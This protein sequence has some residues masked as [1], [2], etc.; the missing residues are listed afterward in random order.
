M[1]VL[2]T[3]PAEDAAPFAAALA[4]RGHAAVLEP[5]LSLAPAPEAQAPL[6]L[7]GVQA[8]LFTSANG[9]RAFAGLSGERALP[10][11]AVGEASAE[12]ARAAGFPAVESAGG[13]VEDLARLVAARLEPGAGALYHGAARKLAGDLKGALEAQGFAVRRAILYEAQP[14]RALT[15]AT[16]TALREGKIDAVSFF[17][18]RT[19]K[20]F[21]DLV[22]GAGLADIMASVDAACLS[23]AVAEVLRVLPWRHVRVAARPDRDAL[24]ECIDDLAGTRDG[25]PAE[26][27]MPP[28]PPPEEN[29][30]ETTEGNPEETPA[31]D[32]PAQAVIARFGGIRPMAHKLEIAVS[33]V[34]GWR[35][36]GS[37]PAARHAQ[38]A[39][40]AESQGIALA[41]ALLA[42]SDRHPDA[43]GEPDPEP[44]PEAP[45]RSPGQEREAE[46]GG[47]WAADSGDTSSKDKAPAEPVGGEAAPLAAASP[48][49]APETAQ[50]PARE[51][52]VAPPAGNAGR[53]IGAFLVA[54]LLLIA[55]AAGAV[56][57][58][59][60]WQPMLAS[61]DAGSAKIEALEAR[62]AALEARPPG[63]TEA[64]LGEARDAIASLR[65]ELE[66]LDM[67][68]A[69]LDTGAEAGGNT[70]ELRAA[71]SDLEGRNAALEG[72]VTAELAALRAAIA[73]TEDRLA[74]LGDP[75]A[76]GNTEELAA[77]LAE[78]ETRNSALAG[79]LSGLRAE[80]AALAE[81]RAATPVSESAAALAILQMRDALRGAA[82]FQGPLQALDAVLAEAEGAQA[83]A[84]GAALAPL[85]PYAAEGAPAL[86]TLQA[87]FP[88]VA[89]AVVAQAQGGEGDDVL[90]NAVRE[91][92]SLFT[93]RRVGPVEGESAEAV[94]ARSEAHLNGG[95]LAS[96]VAELEALSG[97]AAEA[98]APWRA[99]AEARLQAEA[100]LERL[101]GLLIAGRAAD[102]G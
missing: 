78:M 83:E 84:L 74:A 52:P 14:A 5:M 38:I 21:V 28:E 8:V 51:A 59:T 9:V 75:A 89:R 47:P 31:E 46:D 57:T 90:S 60:A 20:T 81:A 15:E 19:A 48:E 4:A 62:L 43:Q 101:G 17:S 3:R 10:V 71:L 97:P 98:A 66:G 63:A 35:E 36:R 82:P 96:A 64:A 32:N 56:L 79:E 73:G 94:V 39:A 50:E 93:L 23:A 72:E 29:A 99:R 6:D 100:A 67:R 69:A 92:S 88:A 16:R 33:T 49:T 95:D 27:A 53:W 26:E 87:E 58:R 37:I 41:P 55:G 76:S 42:E 2:V 54:A 12:A 102:R 70:E 11:F 24:L 65:G 68:L 85:R 7:E 1:R 13:D 18:P 22:Q 34:Q 44:N 91:V 25:R 30:E 61:G 80:L 86:K 40:A 45:E 77:A